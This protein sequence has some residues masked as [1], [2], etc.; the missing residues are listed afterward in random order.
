M[1]SK[2]CIISNLQGRYLRSPSDCELTQ[3]SDR[4]NAHN[5][6]ETCRGFQVSAAVERSRSGNGAHVWM[7]FDCPVLAAD[8]RRPIC[9][10][11]TRTMEK[12]H[13]IGLDSYDRLFP[14]Q[15]TM[16]KGGFGNLI[17]LPLQRGPREQDNSVFL[18][19]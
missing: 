18:N 2:H 5:L 8:A 10:L 11:L 16:P 13:A 3:D 1:H 19:E 9:A 4:K 14:S 17:A 15:D 6:G 12:R 7:F